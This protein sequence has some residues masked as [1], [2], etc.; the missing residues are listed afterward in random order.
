MMTDGQTNIFGNSLISRR[1]PRTIL[2]KIT[3]IICYTHASHTF[4]DA[5]KIDKPSLKGFLPIKNIHI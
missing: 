1:I 3:P 4:W 5:I 2:V